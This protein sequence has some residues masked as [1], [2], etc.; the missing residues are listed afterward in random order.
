MI[1][2]SILST[3]SYIHVPLEIETSRYIDNW[4]VK[5]LVIFVGEKRVCELA[6]HA[7]AWKLGDQKMGTNELDA[8]EAALKYFK[9]RRRGDK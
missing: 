4:G 3:P 1:R 5:H 6:W 8:V 7:D 9:Y 2:K